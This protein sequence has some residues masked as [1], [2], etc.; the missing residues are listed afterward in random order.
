MGYC[1]HSL[2]AKLTA[3]RDYFLA[4]GA[5]EMRTAYLLLA[6]TGEEL[7]E[8]EDWMAEEF[9]FNRLFVGPTPPAA[10][11]VASWYID[12]E[13]EV[14]GKI[15][16]QMREWY[17]TLGLAVPAAGAHPDDHIGYEL[18]VCRTLLLNAADDRTD[19]L[20]I[21]QAFCSEHLLAWIP[22]FHAQVKSIAGEESVPA[23]MT[24]HL[25]Q[26]LHTICTTGET[27]KETV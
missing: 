24:Q 1:E 17:R 6:K 4:T 7:P 16:R 10:P 26:L 5:E 20:E 14:M 13:Q 8:R 18:D 27:A 9:L 23:L 19:A 2:T 12:P 21:C 22:A 25:L 11:P 3:L 15:T